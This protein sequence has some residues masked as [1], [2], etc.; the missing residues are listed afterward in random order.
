MDTTHF[1]YTAEDL[2]SHK[3]QKAGLLV[4]KP[5]FDRDGADLLV[6]MNV[7]DGTKFCRVQC[8]GRSLLNSISSNVEVLKD[9]V[10]EGFLLFLYISDEDE[11]NSNLFC[12]FADD[13]KN[14]WKLKTHKESSKDFYR[15]S[16]SK[17]NYKKNLVSFSLNN[18]TFY[19]IKQL[20][21]EV[22]SHKE[23]KSMMV[24]IIEKQSRAIELN[25]KINKLEKLTEEI[26]N[27][28]EMMNLISANI[29]LIQEK[30]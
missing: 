9:Y 16:I 20:I 22:D 11:T 21:K 19:T 26:K 30:I 28:E 4:V 23:F 6:L 1:A 24:D 18:T 17:K 12:F 10:T 2:I 14:N 5:K 15:L 29:K 25:K 13:I 3:L 27:L 7:N 8:K